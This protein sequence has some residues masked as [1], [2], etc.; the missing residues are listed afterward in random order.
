MTTSMIF[1]GWLDSVPLQHILQLSV[2]IWEW[3][4]VLA[5]W[6]DGY[7]E[8]GKGSRCPT[9]LIGN[10][11]IA[12]RRDVHLVSLVLVGIVLRNPPGTPSS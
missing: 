7:K 2:K 1:R 4:A 6:G 12:E 9:S 11:R 10:H 3:G 8:N 5:K